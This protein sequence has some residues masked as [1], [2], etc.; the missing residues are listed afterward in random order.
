[1]NL[2]HYISE[3]KFIVQTVQLDRYVVKMETKN[4]KHE[5]TET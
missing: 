1:M 3:I 5:M 2:N 4:E